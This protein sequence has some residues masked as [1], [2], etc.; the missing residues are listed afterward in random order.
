MLALGIKV[1]FLIFLL[2]NSA[3]A[4]EKGSYCRV[5]IEGGK[6]DFSSSSDSTPSHLEL[7][8]SMGFR[9]LTMQSVFLSELLQAIL[10]DAPLDELIEDIAIRIGKDQART[11]LIGGKTAYHAAIGKAYRQMLGTPEGDAAFQARIER[12]WGVKREFFLP[13][14]PQFLINEG[15]TPFIDEA[16]WVRSSL[17]PLYFLPGE[18]SSILRVVGKVC[19][20]REDH[21]KETVVVKN[22][23]K[24]HRLKKNRRIRNI[25]WRYPLAPIDCFIFDAEIE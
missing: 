5:R 10:D 8:K 17:E 12:D 19:P 15:V 3:L 11:L 20:P 6:F 2:S 16:H 14:Y 7:A 13:V 21:R 1:Y 9:P 18:G 22:F 24:S 23:L 25:A 4:G